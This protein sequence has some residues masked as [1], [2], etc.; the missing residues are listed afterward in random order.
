MQSKIL[1]F[2]LIVGGSIFYLTKNGIIDP[3]RMTPASITTTETSLTA[4]SAE[5]EQLLD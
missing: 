4:F 3:V 5:H 1:L 2:C